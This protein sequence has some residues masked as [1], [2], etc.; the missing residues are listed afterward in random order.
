[1]YVFKAF[2]TRKERGLRGGQII[3]FVYISVN[4][5]PYL[6]MSTK[7][8]GK[9]IATCFSVKKKTWIPTRR[10]CIMDLA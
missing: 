3:P 6:E 5:V 1:M 7:V 8:A 2:C 10:H 4:L 9:Q